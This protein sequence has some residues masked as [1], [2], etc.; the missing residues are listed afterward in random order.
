MET[1]EIIKKV[2]KIEIKTKHLV[3]GLMTGA[4]H[5]V[6]KGR[7]IEFSEV[8]EYVPGDDVR[9]IDWKVT[10]RMNH[11]FVKEFIEE[12]DLTM[13]IIFDVSA[14]GEFG[15]TKSKKEQ[16]TELAATLMFSAIQNNDNVGLMLFSDRMERF[17]P[18][19]KGKKHVLKL[20]RELVTYEPVG[21]TTDIGVALSYFSKIIKRGSIIFIISDFYSSDFLLPLKM[22]RQKHDVIAINIH[23]IR[24]L[25]IPDVGYI[26]LEDEETG[27]QIL[28]DTSDALFRKRY[29]GIMK[30]RELGL[31]RHMHKLGIDMIAL[32][33][34]Q[35]YE[36]PLR[37]FFRTRERRRG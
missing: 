9:S 23:D 14:S 25:E 21:K 30:E 10:A 35:T 33:S 20:V 18:A 11:P 4:Y 37:N 6:F 24:E 19:R 7:G 22:I 16:A 36:T 28:V 31:T 8:R 15:A 1:K 12:R 32:H 13:Y 34:D 2:K 17:I 26:E 5:S 27:E 3:E 29:E